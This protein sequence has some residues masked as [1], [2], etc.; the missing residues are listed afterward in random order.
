MVADRE[1]PDYIFAMRRM[2]IEFDKWLGQPRRGRFLLVAPGATVAECFIY[3]A[4]ERELGAILARKFLEFREHCRAQ[5]GNGRSFRVNTAGLKPEIR[6][7]LDLILE[8]LREIG[9]TH[10]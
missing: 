5:G 6:A 2:A 4:D 10:R 8:E 7:K 1:L 3:A 9:L